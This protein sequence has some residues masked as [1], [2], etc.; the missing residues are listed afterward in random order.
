SH[1][2]G[3]YVENRY[4]YQTKA[5]LKKFIIVTTSRDLREAE[6]LPKAKELLAGVLENGYE[7][8][9]RRHTAQ[10]KDRWAKADREI[11]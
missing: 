9:K 11:K 1:T 2:A 10:W 3:M 6:L 7:E 4:S 8:A 5:S